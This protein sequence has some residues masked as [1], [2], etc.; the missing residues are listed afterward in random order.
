M[1]YPFAAGAGGCLLWALVFGIQNTSK[2]NNSPIKKIIKRHG[3]KIYS[4]RSVAQ[5]ATRRGLF[6]LFFICFIWLQGP[7]AVPR[8]KLRWAGWTVQ[9]GIAAAGRR[10]RR[11]GPLTVSMALH[12]RERFIQP[13]S[14]EK[15]PACR[16]GRWPPSP[17]APGPHRPARRPGG[18]AAHTCA[19]PAGASRP[20]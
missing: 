15:E 16:N 17:D 9:P 19:L 5:S 14:A 8:S 11:H 1:L 4:R 7:V 10:S 2:M 3:G 12:V 20:G 13:P 18:S 6:L